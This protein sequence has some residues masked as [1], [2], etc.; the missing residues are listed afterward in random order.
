MLDKD[1][2]EKLKN[3]PKSKTQINNFNLP[4]LEGKLTSIKML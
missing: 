3:L 2:G 1:C 4:V